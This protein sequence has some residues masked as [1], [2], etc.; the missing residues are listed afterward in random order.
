MFEITYDTTELIQAI[1]RLEGLSYES[2][3]KDTGQYIE[4]Q[5]QKRLKAGV[6][7]EGDPFTP[8]SEKYAERKASAGFGGQ[9]ILTATG[10][11][12]RSLITEILGDD[13]SLTTVHGT[14]APIPGLTKVTEEMIAIAERHEFGLNIPQRQFLDINDVDIDWIMDR[15]SKIFAPDLR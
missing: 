8:L 12:G 9:P 10:A 5:I 7:V 14:H 11:L 4:K 2:F 3:L 13:E 6:D 15:F 1:D